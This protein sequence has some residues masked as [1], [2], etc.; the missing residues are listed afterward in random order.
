MLYYHILGLGKV[1]APSYLT[2]TPWPLLKQQSI[3]FLFISSFNFLK[4]GLLTPNLVYDS[5][6]FNVS[7]KSFSGAKILLTI[8]L[9]KASLGS[10]L[11]AYN[12][13]SL[14]ASLSVILS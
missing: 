1:A 3:E 8:F 11:L 5:A 4:I 7:S 10:N 9:S 2:P 14:K 13:N 12:T 6:N